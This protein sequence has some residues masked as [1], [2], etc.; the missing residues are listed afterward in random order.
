MAFILL[1]ENIWYVSL[2][3]GTLMQVGTG[4]V[5]GMSD[6]KTNRFA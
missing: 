1:I 2:T 6:L 4:T 5:V 3:Y